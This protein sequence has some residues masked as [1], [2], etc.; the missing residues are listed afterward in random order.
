MPKG[1]PSQEF[2]PIQE[3]RDGIL[4]LKNGSLRAVLLA[5]SINLALKS[6]DEQKA[7]IAQFQSFFNTLDFPIQIVV[8]SRKH[9]LRPYLITLEDRLKD[10]KEDLLRL[11][12][13][14]YIEFI[15]S[16][17]ENVNIMKKNFFVVVPYERP[18]MGS[19]G[20]SGFMSGLFGGSKKSDKNLSAKQERFEEARSQLE[21][22]IA[23]VQGGLSR[24]GVHTDQLE[25]QAVVELFHS[26][27]NPGE[28][29]KPMSAQQGNES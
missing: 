3:I 24:V 9:D 27:F 2:V 6:A 1:T 22:R 17:S 8:Q 29:Q 19:S 23:I 26:T 10:L 15:R 5:S 28:T 21:Q 25:S 12:T 14:E 18:T 16:F 7:V 11:Q 20:T 13:Q 4:V